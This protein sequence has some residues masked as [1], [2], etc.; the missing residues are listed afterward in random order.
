[1]GVYN[2]FTAA[3]VTQNSDLF[4][5]ADAG[6]RECYFRWRGNDTFDFNALY[7]TT[8]ATPRTTAN[9]RPTGDFVGMGLD[10]INV[11]NLQPG[12]TVPSAARTV[13]ALVPQGHPCQWHGQNLSGAPAV[14]NVQPSRY[15]LMVHANGITASQA[16]TL[17]TLSLQFLKD[18]GVTGVP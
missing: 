7:N 6:G 1:M 5:L 8:S 17:R 10:G 9:L 13:E 11:F 14:G 3:D 12:G 15:S 4:G 2:V 16:Q 18:I